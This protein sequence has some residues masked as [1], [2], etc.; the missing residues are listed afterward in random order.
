MPKYV[1]GLDQVL[2]RI[3]KELSLVKGRTAKG[4][5][6]AMKHLEEEM[7]TVQPLVPIDTKF[8][9]ESWYIFPAIGPGGPIVTA[10]YTAYYAPYVHEKVD[11]INWTRPGSGPK[12]L[13]I[14]YE[15][16]RRQMFLIV[17]QHASI[18]R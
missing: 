16:N 2:Y 9:R 3:N 1:E 4:L 14:H 10:G 7:D 12:W 5:V 18:K 11:A 15:R 17:A 8:M 13:Q 6:A